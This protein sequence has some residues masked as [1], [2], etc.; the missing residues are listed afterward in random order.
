[1][2][3]KGICLLVFDSSSTDKC[4][5]SKGMQMAVGE[6][7]SCGRQVV[8]LAHTLLPGCTEHHNLIDCSAAVC[9]TLEA[10]YIPACA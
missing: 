5:T 3:V 4:V 1:M 7:A 9:C 8:S 6:E 2:L 10:T